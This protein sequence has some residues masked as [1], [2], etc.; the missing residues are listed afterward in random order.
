MT[1]QV[2]PSVRFQPAGAGT[3]K[4]HLTGWKPLSEHSPDMTALGSG[5]T[6]V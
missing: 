2:G 6:R 3:P 5:A 4:R 1:Q